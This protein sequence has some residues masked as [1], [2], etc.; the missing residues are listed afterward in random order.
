[1]NDFDRWNKIKQRIDHHDDI[2]KFWKERDIW[3]ICLGQNVGHEQNGKNKEFERPVL[4]IKK[5]NYR[6][7]WGVPLTS[8]VKEKHYCVPFE[9]QNRT[10]GA[11][12]TQMSLID[13]ARF[14][15]KMGRL[16]VEDYSKIKNSI[17]EYLS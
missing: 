6:I 14:I 16:G 4:V 5:F 13:A 2:P 11:L 8:Q 7:F 10:Q 9:F 1:M 15:S 17:K 3:W 12:I